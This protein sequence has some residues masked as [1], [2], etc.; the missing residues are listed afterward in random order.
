MGYSEQQIKELKTTINNSDA[1][2]VLIATPIDLGRLLD[3]KTPAVR[4]KY[5]L[6]EIGEP[7]LENAL[8]SC[9]SQIYSGVRSQY[10]AKGWNPHIFAVFLDQPFPIME[11]SNPPE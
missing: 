1:E 2:M 7:T 8:Q 6:Q 4:L 3:L 9:F 5:E 10:N 11:V